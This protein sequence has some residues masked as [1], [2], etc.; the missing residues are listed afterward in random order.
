MPAPV[1][2]TFTQWGLLHDNGWTEQMETRGA[3][4]RRIKVGWAVG[5]VVVRR[6]VSEWVP[7]DPADP[8]PG[9]QQAP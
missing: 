9:T 1:A 6:E 3:A 4:E 7:V 8:D 2:V 5:A